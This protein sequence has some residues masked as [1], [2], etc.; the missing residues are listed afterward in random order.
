M[1]GPEFEGI[2]P[3]QDNRDKYLTER[4][5]YRLLVPNVPRQDVDVFARDPENGIYGLSGL[6][7]DTIGSYLSLQRTLDTFDDLTFSPD[8][9]SRLPEDFKTKLGDCLYPGIALADLEIPTS[10]KVLL[11]QMMAAD[12]LSDVL[13]SSPVDVWVSAQIQ[14]DLEEMGCKQELGLQ[15]ID[16]GSLSLQAKQ[17]L[18]DV[19]ERQERQAE[20]IAVARQRY[21]EGIP[22]FGLSALFSQDR[23]RTKLDKLT[24][25]DQQFSLAH[26]VLSNPLLVLYGEIMEQAKKE[27]KSDKEKGVEEETH[28][29]DW[30]DTPYDIPS[31][32]Q[33]QWWDWGRYNYKGDVPEKV[34]DYLRPS[35]AGK[36][37]YQRLRAETSDD[38]Q[39]VL[40]AFWRTGDSRHIDLGDESWMRNDLYLQPD[41]RLTVHFKDDIYD[42]IDE[43]SQIHGLSGS[44]PHYRDVAMVDQAVKWI[45][46]EMEAMQK[47]KESWQEN[48]FGPI[49]NIEV[50]LASA[51]GINT[52]AASE[53]IKELPQWFVK[54]LNQEMRYFYKLFSPK[55][56][57]ASMDIMNI[58][59]RNP[60]E[61]YSSLKPYF[62]LSEERLKRYGQLISTP[63]EFY[64]DLDLDPSA[65]QDEA[66]QAF[67]KIAQE[68]KAIHIKSAEEFDPEEWNHMNER[69][70]RVTRAYNVISRKGI[71]GSR[72]TTLGRISDYFTPTPQE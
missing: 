57:A 19:M 34:A 72:V 42:E 20:V 33:Q 48:G 32:A 59:M 68:T 17:Y 2:V 69:F 30:D 27:R 15:H 58:T 37:M 65:T 4:A 29:R 50:T 55:A 44:I 54:A 3:Q 23:T 63:S 6:K 49:A 41:G 45:S 52:D 5:E 61:W 22:P 28:P 38:Q 31:E 70:V 18:V 51:L 47:A 13:S 67:R 60:I 12:R 9:L 25:F 24:D 46:A 21:P 11:A 14:K 10:D 7:V 39:E 66:R 71:Q 26:Q 64:K 56:T 40:S 62:R 36:T 16:Y 1:A 35:Y 43:G 8:F 53:Q